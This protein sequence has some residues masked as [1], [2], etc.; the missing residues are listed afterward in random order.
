MRVL[1]LGAP[2]SGKGTQGVRIAE[3]YDA[4]HLSTGDV[5]RQEVEEDS[6]IGQ[7][8]YPYMQAGDLVPD[9]LI[10]SIIRKRLTDPDAPQGYVIDG[11][12]RTVPQAK[13][14]YEIA[15][16]VGLTLD[17]AVCLELEHDE[18]IRRLDD[19]GQAHGRVDDAAEVVRH[20]IE[21]YE[22]QTLPLLE[23]YAGRG[24]LIEIDAIGAVDEVTERIFAALDVVGSSG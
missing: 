14:A 19:R 22:T 9:E 3:R 21:V 24:I 16:G 23:Y 12:P 4:E 11:F 6:A 5:L 2:G 1:L 18:L 20:R 13:E 7:E 10:M 8:A 15:D 17:A